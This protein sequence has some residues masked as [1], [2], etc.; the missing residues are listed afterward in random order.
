MA[1]T[2]AT[3]ADYERLT[4][5]EV[6]AILPGLDAEGLQ[7]VE[8]RERSGKHRVTVLRRIATLQVASSATPINTAE[9]RVP[10]STSSATPATAATIASSVAFSPAMDARTDTEKTSRWGIRRNI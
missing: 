6:I 4:A 7:R 2:F 9:S 10:E 5:A 8:T 3:D 1:S